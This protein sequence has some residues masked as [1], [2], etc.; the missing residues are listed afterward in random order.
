MNKS[1]NKR[2]LRVIILFIILM[3]GISVFIIVYFRQQTKQL[4]IYT[5]S[6]EDYGH[7]YAYICDNRDDNMYNS[8][9][10]EALDS[11][12]GSGSYIEFMGKNL[13]EDYDSAELLKIAV[14]AG[15]DGIIFQ[16]DES[17]KTKELI[18]WADEMGVPVITV[19]RDNASSERKSFVGFAYYELGQ[20]YGAQILEHG[21]K[22]GT[23]IL[24]LVSSDANNTSQN[25]TFQGI[26]DT[27]SKA[28]ALEGIN[29]KT[30]AVS[31]TSA[32][33][34]EEA[35]SSL[36]M[37]DELPDIIVCLSEVSTTCVCQALIDYNHVG[38]AQV[39][40]FFTNSTILSAI[41]KNVIAATVTIDT[42]Q[43]GR[44]CVEALTEYENYGYVN[45]YMPADIY[46]IDN[47]NVEEYY[48][49]GGEDANE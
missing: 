15:M 17:Q 12:S 14:Y 31:D 30:M 29:L 23:D 3:I 36:I 28:K 6:D 32:F 27:L 1:E 11:S 43:M 47:R 16:A 48:G 33:G 8:I 39:Y 49:S 2:T 38:D 10:E 21:T 5:D 20:T 34:A 18:N 9:Y 44:Y 7:H 26:I 22:K 24:V 45:E 35:I 46:V 41:E 13:T 37:G 40:G 42:K 19:G 25:I 4:A